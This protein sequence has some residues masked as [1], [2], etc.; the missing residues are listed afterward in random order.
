MPKD[1]DEKPR[2]ISFGAAMKE[3]FGRPQLYILCA[4]VLI[5]A[6]ARLFYGSLKMQTEQVMLWFDPDR[7][8]AIVQ[9]VSSAPWS[10]PLDDVFIHFDFARATAQ[11]HPFEWIAGNGYSSGGTSLLYP[12]VLAIGY[13]SG[14]N[15][16][17]LML[18]A[19]IVA[20]VSILGTLVAARRMFAQLP[21]WTALVA[22]PIFLSV[23]ALNWTL[24]SG[25]EVAMF[26]GLWGLCYVTWDELMLRIERG[27][28]TRGFTLFFGL[29]CSLLVASRPEAAPLVAI[30]ALWAAFNVKRKGSFKA[31][32]VGTLLI[33]VPGAAIVVAH[34]IANHVLTGSS[35]AAGALAK[36]EMHHPYFTRAEVWG[37][38]WFFVK[39]QFLRLSDYHF[40]APIMGVPGSGFLLWPLGLLSL[41]FPTTR[42]AGILLW[43]SLLL[44]IALIGLNG[45]VRWQ[46]E[47][48]CMPAVAW[49]LLSVALG[50]AGSLN[51]ARE[52]IA[53][54]QAQR[55]AF[56]RYFVPLSLGALLTIFIIGQ[57]PRFVDQVWFFGRASRNILEQHVRAAAAL[58]KAKPRLRRVL[59]SDAGAIPY[60]SG[61]SAIDLIGLGGYAKLPMASASRQGVG[62]AVELLEYVPLTHLPDV[63]ALYPSWWGDFVLWFGRIADEFPVRGN[64]ICGGAS[65]VI[66]APRWAPLIH[67][68]QPI[69]L[70][71]HQRLVDAVDIADV[72][73]EKAHH[74]SWDRKAQGYVTMK[75]LPSERDPTTDLWDA[76]RLLSTDMT[77]YFTVNGLDQNS[78]N[79]GAALL[80]RTA[81]AQPAQ[82]EVKHGNQLVT[83]LQIEPS[84]H[85]QEHVVRL[86]TTSAAMKMSLRPTSGEIHIFHIFVVEDISSLSRPVTDDQSGPS[87]QP[88]TR[89][90]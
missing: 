38:W 76:G 81:P 11:G 57:R 63:M 3:S 89:Q 72:I 71:P 24:F 25:M 20:C 36:L 17:D 61:L 75:L 50:V 34:M 33:G 65:M 82:L 85:W 74:V 88:G 52:R 45:Q 4:A 54:N 53:H 62:A 29:C 40:G 6:N 26:L 49:L 32:V 55:P 69:A 60:A 12:F 77:L 43:I 73:N 15:D 2:R 41:A 44:W 14:L 10:A 87:S 56:I 37:S 42:R 22:P 28:N 8:S 51:W 84:D 21:G 48:Y 13:L 5:L 79:H 27:T 80:I 46:N 7:Y 78:A 47:R 31:A 1:K 39:Y 23:G 66:Y 19:A 9:G 90:K 58:S 86:D 16:L 70:A 35:S 59:L 68:G 67:S 30:F 18:W 83:L 64:V